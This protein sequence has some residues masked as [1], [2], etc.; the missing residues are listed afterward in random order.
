MDF[1]A[2]LYFI[3]PENGGR[4]SYATSGYRPHIQFDFDEMLTS[5]QQIYLDK[6]H[7]FPGETVLA[8]ISI[9]AREHFINK[10]ENGMKFNF[11][12][13]SNLI[14]NGEILEIINHS[15]LKK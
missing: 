5:G 10:L 15:L 2:E 1:I 11:Y 8:E 6:K 4:K 3:S 12:E 14:G 9:L 13:G 7:V